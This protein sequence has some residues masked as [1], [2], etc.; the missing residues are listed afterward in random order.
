MKRAATSLH[1]IW[2][3]FVSCYMLWISTPGLS[4]SD[5]RHEP[6]A[7]FLPLLALIWITFAIALFFGRLWAWF[8]SFAFT[9]FSLFTGVWF[10]LQ[11]VSLSIPGELA[12]DLVG[13]FIAFVVLAALLQTRHSYFHR[14]ENVA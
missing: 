5:V 2:A 6:F 13:I 7:L 3:G 10:S 14:H 12:F 9:V 4:W 11:A 1:L 8:G